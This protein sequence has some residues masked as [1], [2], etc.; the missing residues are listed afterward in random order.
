MNDWVAIEQAILSP[1]ASFASRS[2]GRK[3][4]EPGH[5]FRSPFHRD[6]DRVLHSAAFRRLKYKTQVFI[7]HEKD[8]FRTRLTHTL[9]VSQIARTIAVRMGLNEVLTETIALVHDIGHTPFGHAG[10]EV[11]DELMKDEG[12]FEHNLHALRIVDLLERRYVDFPGLNL[13]WEVREAIAKHSRRYSEKGQLQDEFGSPIPSLE[14][15]IVEVADEIAYDTHDLDDALNSGLISFSDVEGLLAWR[16]VLDKIPDRSR[17]DDELY[18][19]Y[20]VRAIINLWVT[21]VINTLQ[22]AIKYNRIETIDD[23]RAL[24]KRVVGFSEEI[25]EAKLELKRFLYANVYN[26]PEVK[27]RAEHYQWL[28]RELFHLFMDRPG[29]LPG[30]FY[31]DIE[32][33]GKKRVICDYIAGMTDRYAINEYKKIHKQHKEI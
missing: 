5:P 1:Y 25:D 15:Q 11:L 12:G 24:D 20:V 17:L 14:A 30:H 9:E 32:R 3:Y 6:R 21:D 27:E 31:S 4:K 19:H 29:L 16:L 8:Y 13:S 2:Q 33:F 7:Y 22:D 26:H 23:V 28:L 18:R 10:E